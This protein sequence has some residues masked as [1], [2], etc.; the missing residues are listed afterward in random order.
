MPWVWHKLPTDKLKDLCN[1]GH[2]NIDNWV[3]I[4]PGSNPGLVWK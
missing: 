2:N 1:W 3:N 4:V